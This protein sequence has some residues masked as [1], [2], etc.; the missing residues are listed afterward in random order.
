MLGAKHTWI[1]AQSVDC[2]AQSV[3]PCFALAIRELTHDC[4]IPGLRTHDEREGPLP[5]T[6]PALTMA[7]N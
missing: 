6:R 1:F 7:S 5:A 3:D 4:A 2:P